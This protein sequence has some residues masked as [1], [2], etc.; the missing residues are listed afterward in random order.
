[1]FQYSSNFTPECSTLDPLSLPRQHVR[2][3]PYLATQDTVLH[4][5]TVDKN[6]G[7]VATD[8]DSLENSKEASREAQ[9]TQ[10]LL[11]TKQ[12]YK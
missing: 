11:I 2:L 10:G 12:L 8:P 1:M 4:K 5:R 9:G 6:V 3:D 7:S